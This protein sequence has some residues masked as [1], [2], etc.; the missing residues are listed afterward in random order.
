MQRMLSS[1]R[2]NMKKVIFIISNLTYKSKHKN[3]ERN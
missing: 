2:V 3:H 1:V